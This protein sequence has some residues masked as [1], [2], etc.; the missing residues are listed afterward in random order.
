MAF[1][2][3]IKHKRWN[4]ILN[5]IDDMSRVAMS[6]TIREYAFN[7]DFTWWPLWVIWGKLMLLG[8]QFYISRI[9]TNLIGNGLRWRPVSIFY[10]IGGAL[11]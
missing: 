9:P 10:F 6:R 4:R 2:G 3:P 5:P 7:Y 1:R 11:S 8:I